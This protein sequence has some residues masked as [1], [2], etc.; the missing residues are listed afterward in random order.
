MYELLLQWGID[1]LT[2]LVSTKRNQDSAILLEAVKAKNALVVERFRYAREACQAIAELSMTVDAELEVFRSKAPDTD[3]SLQATKKFMGALK[4]EFHPSHYRRLKKL[5][6]QFETTN[7]LLSA[8]SVVMSDLLHF[9]TMEKVAIEK[10]IRSAGNLSRT[11]RGLWTIYS[12][13]LTSLV[14]LTSNDLRF[15][16]IDSPYIEQAEALA[17]EDFHQAMTFLLADSWSGKSFRL[18]LE[19]K[20]GLKSFWKSIK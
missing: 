15:W 2:K 10:K 11:Y 17:K 5:R 1:S 4:T 14:R 3:G 7:D 16:L 13:I 18:S 8:Y 6:S 12:E 19:T 9:S 20:E